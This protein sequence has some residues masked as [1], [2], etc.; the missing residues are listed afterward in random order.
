MEVQLVQIE[1]NQVVVSSRQIA[2]DFGK[3]HKHVLDSIRDILAAENSATK[4]FYEST[5]DNR[6]K[7]Y[8]EYLMNRDGFSLLV[9]GFTG[10]KALEWKVRYIQ[11]FNAMEAKLAME[12]QDSY[13]IADP[14]ARALKWAEEEKKRRALQATCSQQ[15]QLIGEL[16]PKADYTDKIL[17][18]KS[19]VPITAI[20]KDYG[21]SGQ[22]LNKIL[23]GLKII[24]R[25]GNQWLLY[26]KYQACGYTSSETVQIETS[27]GP[28]V[29]LN[30]K[31]TQKGRL[32]LYEMLKK[33][34]II[35]M[36]ER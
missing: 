10:S 11:A 9:M 13:M 19:L 27:E 8:P 24:Y 25:I 28:K 21:M 6:G 16:K 12:H 34:N 14:I 7:E 26:S 35:P 22:A 32:F 23:H 30:T 17:Q 18:S 33:Q 29:V 2:K 15:E 20:A 5:Y 3:Q 4:F 1:N 31:W 36:I